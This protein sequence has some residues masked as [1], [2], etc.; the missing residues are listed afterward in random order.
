MQLGAKGFVT[1]NSTSA[2][3]VTAIQTVYNG[4]NFICQEIRDIMQNDYQ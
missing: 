4:G 2:E 1:K 3:M